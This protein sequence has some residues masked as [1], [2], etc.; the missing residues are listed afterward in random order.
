MPSLWTGSTYSFKMTTCT[1]I[2]ILDQ[3][4]IFNNLSKSYPPLLGLNPQKRLDLVFRYISKIFHTYCGVKGRTYK[5]PT[6]GNLY[7]WLCA[8]YQCNTPQQHQLF[9]NQYMMW[10]QEVID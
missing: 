1:S 10:K 6:K 7:D 4:V 9:Y 2:Y 3:E 8:K 5:V